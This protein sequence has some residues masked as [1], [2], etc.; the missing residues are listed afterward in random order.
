MTLVTVYTF[1]HIEQGCTYLTHFEGSC[2]IIVSVVKL[3][4][5]ML[6]SKR[7]Y[8]FDHYD[9]K[10]DGLFVLYICTYDELHS[11]SQQSI[12]AHSVSCNDNN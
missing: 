2:L 3:A 12:I 4:A 6:V 9:C 8:C 11:H 1:Q 10:K 7:F 5:V